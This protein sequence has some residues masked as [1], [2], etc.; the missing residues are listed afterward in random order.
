MQNQGEGENLSRDELKKLKEAKKAAAKAEKEQKKLEREQQEAQRR[1][2]L[3]QSVIKH[4]DYLTSDLYGDINL[5]RSETNNAFNFT[6]IS[7]LSEDHIGQTVRVRARLHGTRIKGNS[8][9]I[10]LRKGFNSVQAVA[11]KSDTVPKELIKYIDNTQKESVVDVEAV[12]AKPA[13]P[14]DF[15]S[16]KTI[17]LNVVRF[18]VVSRSTPDL[19]FLIEDA[20]RTM[21]REEFNKQ[22]EPE[23]EEKK[24][25]KK[26]EITEESK[27]VKMPTVGLRQRLQT[28]VLDLRV[29][30]NRAIFTIQSGVCQLFREFLISNK[31]IE[32]HSPKILGGS[33]EGGCEVFKT[34]YF[35]KTA[36]LAQS[37]QLFKQMAIMGDFERVFEIGPVFR[38]ENSNTPRHLCE[39]TGLDLEMEIYES[40]YEVMHIIGNVFNYMFK[41]LQTR[42]AEECEAVNQQFPFEPFLF[43]EEPLMLTFQEG[44]ELLKEAGFEQN[45]FVDITTTNEKMLGKIVRDKYHTDFYILHRYPHQ[46]RPFY[47]MICKDDAR[48]TCSYDVFM[49]GEEIISGAQR[50]HDVAFLKERATF[51]GM[52]PD[53]INYYCESF[54]FGACP[55]GGFG[56]GLERV[57]KLF[58]NLHNVRQT[59]LFPRTPDIL[60]P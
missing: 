24:E 36:S 1:L 48:Y 52:N 4:V 20:S 16:K 35:G 5:I 22:D 21:T 29:P 14:I 15:C 30:A 7:D 55:H 26:E 19:P 46:A 37:P 17:E 40:Y 60:V 11:F 23:E 45:P 25:E 50:I 28:R 42:Y 44:V 2:Q 47:T 39:F 12:V 18:F 56:T 38:A 9:F 8:A 27:E 51:K 54:G 10:I 59:S 31:F 49:R 43:L 58:L 34:D 53:D 32:I 3:A 41:G 33:S 6:H 57:V 13:E